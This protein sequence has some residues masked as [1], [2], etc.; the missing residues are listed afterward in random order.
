MYYLVVLS[1]QDPL[2][3]PVCTRYLFYP[4][5][6]IFSSPGTYDLDVVEIWIYTLSWHV[7]RCQISPC[8]YITTRNQLGVGIYGYHH[9]PKA[10]MCQV[11]DY[12]LVLKGIWNTCVVLA[13]YQKYSYRSVPSCQYICVGQSIKHHYCHGINHIQVEMKLVSIPL[14]LNLYLVSSA[15]MRLLWYLDSI[16]K[17]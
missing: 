2:S 11:L 7:Y 10:I 9:Y 8:K 5:M 4:D 17:L 12:Y 15:S 3:V 13:L 14:I 16:A 6:H 1:N